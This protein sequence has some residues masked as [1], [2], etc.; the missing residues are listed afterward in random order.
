MEYFLASASW[1]AV[2]LF[3]FCSVFYFCF[4]FY[5]CSD[6]LFWGREFYLKNSRDILGFIR[7]KSILS[8]EMNTYFP[9]WRNTNNNIKVTR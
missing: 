3:C 4:V 7:G 1:L 9:E 6:F 8:Y 5:F 2:L